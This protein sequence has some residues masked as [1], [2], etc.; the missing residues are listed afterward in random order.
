M[1]VCSG[2]RGNKFLICVGHVLPT[3]NTKY[4]LQ[5]T[6]MSSKGHVLCKRLGACLAALFDHLKKHFDDDGFVG[7]QVVQLDLGHLIQDVLDPE[8]QDVST[9]FGQVV[10]VVHCRATL[11][12]NCHRTASATMC[13][14]TSSQSDVIKQNASASEQRAE[15]PIGPGRLRNIGSISNR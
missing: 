4:T 6:D 1:V 12:D 5:Q 11:V 13:H 2:K 14:V 9:A 15:V 10:G 3:A 8:L 7:R